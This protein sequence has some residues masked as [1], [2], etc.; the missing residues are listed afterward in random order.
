MPSGDPIRLLILAVLGAMW[1]STSSAQTVAKINLEC[2]SFGSEPMLECTVHLRNKDDT[3]LRGGKVILS[4]SMPS[5][6]MAH[7]IRPVVAAP[8]DK[9]GEYRGT[10]EL[11][12]PGV[13]AIQVDISKP[14]RERLMQSLRVEFC[15]S[16]KRCPAPRAGQTNKSHR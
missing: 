10:L 7:S 6:P 11:E 15:E 16:G 2:L 4:A 12:M 1:P 5:M 3:P 14:R 13:W 8:I 9:P